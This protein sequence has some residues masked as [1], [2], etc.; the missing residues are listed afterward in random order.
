MAVR[1][2]GR[3]I[4]VHADD[5]DLHVDVMRFFAIIAMCLFAILPHTESPTATSENQPQ[6]HATKA[7]SAD[8]SVSNALAITATTKR[9]AGLSTSAPVFNTEKSSTRKDHDTRRALSP[10]KQA[11][12][13][14]AQ[15][16][17]ESIVASAMLLKSNNVAPRESAS[18]EGEGV[19]FL[20]SDAFALAVANGA[21]TLVYHNQNE[22]LV[23]DPT[24]LRFAR[25]EDTSLQIFGLAASEVPARFHTALPKIQLA[26][27]I[28]AQWF[29][30]LPESTLAYLL[31][32]QRNGRQ[33]AVLND[34]A[35]PI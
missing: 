19:R 3:F 34:R 24:V 10:I 5:S 23:F 4:A 22:S 6:R 33:G 18:K 9:E 8:L 26:D 31:D 16:R 28:E 30:T 1:R 2:Y 21:I 17:P 25:L 35:Q 11:G 32:A 20:N 29:I 13:K 14:E 15:L 27:M 12:M 7:E